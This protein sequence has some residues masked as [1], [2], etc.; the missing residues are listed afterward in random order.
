[1]GNKLTLITFTIRKSTRRVG[2]MYS[3]PFQYETE[4]DTYL[5]ASRCSN[6]LLY[7]FIVV[8]RARKKFNR[9]RRS[10]KRLV[11]IG[12][13]VGLADQRVLVATV[14]ILLVLDSQLAE[15]AD[16]V[17]HLSVVDVA[18]GTA[19]VGKAG[20]DVE[21]VV[22]DGDDD[23]DTNRVGPHHDNGDNVGHT[24]AVLV[25]VE[26]THWVR[27]RLVA[28]LLREPTE[29]TEDSGE[30]V[31][32][33]DGGDQCE[34]REGRATTGNEDK[35]VLSKRNLK[36][37][38]VLDAAVSLDDTTV[39][40]EQG[41]TNNPG[42]KSKLDTE[43]DGDDPDLRKLPFDRAL[44]RVSVVSRNV[45]LESSVL[46][47]I[48]NVAGRLRPLARSVALAAVFHIFVRKA[49]SRR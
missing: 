39:G 45:L 27:D 18:L 9:L 8:S 28:N 31:H 29:D 46:V 40:Q 10:A 43:N 16:D 7:F 6:T 19:E 48:L 11:I 3:A 47:E 30:G 23:G 20:N 24:L 35:P 14:L 49:D 22:G 4:G 33:G 1:M 36:E 17:L 21:E 13:V 41:T 38:N 44:L 25:V 5:P 32:N 34:S 12:I 2:I 26:A 42:G 37:E 15:V